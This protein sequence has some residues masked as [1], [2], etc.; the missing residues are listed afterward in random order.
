MNTGSEAAIQEFVPG[1]SFPVKTPKYFVIQGLEKPQRFGIEDWYLIPAPEQKELLSQGRVNFYCSEMVLLT[2]A[3][4]EALNWK[5]TGPALE[6][7][8]RNEAERDAAAI[9]GKSAKEKLKTDMI[10]M[11]AL[12]SSRRTKAVAN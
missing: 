7:K 3:S 2:T 8:A 5:H 4:L 12:R 10:H 6:E 1:N 11:A 9:E